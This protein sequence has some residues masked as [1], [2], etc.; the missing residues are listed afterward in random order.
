MTCNGHSR[1]ILILGEI[2]KRSERRFENSSAWP[3]IVSNASRDDSDPSVFGSARIE[4]SVY[5]GEVMLW[6]NDQ[7]I[8]LEI[9]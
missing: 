4:A 9:V 8:G 5:I 3:N 2:D 6:P 7:D 1:H